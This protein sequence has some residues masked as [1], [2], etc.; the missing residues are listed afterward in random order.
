MTCTPE[1]KTNNEERYRIDNINGT[2]K[3]LSTENSHHVKKSQ[4]QPKKQTPPV[5]LTWKVI[6]IKSTTKSL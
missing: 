4:I 1:D 3:N 2:K 5:S 6:L